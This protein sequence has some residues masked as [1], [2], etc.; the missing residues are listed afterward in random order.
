M[1]PRYCPPSSTTRAFFRA[2]LLL[3]A[4]SFAWSG[5]AA[6]SLTQAKPDL[7]IPAAE[8]KPAAIPSTEFDITAK[9]PTGTAATTDADPSRRVV[10]QLRL[11][12]RTLSAGAELL[13]I[14][15]RLDGIKVT[16]EP[17]PEVPL[18]SV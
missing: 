12:R 15:G 11:E 3:V 8:L 16:G 7:A 13:T 6:Q 1:R 4:I 2:L 5:S 14:F 10:P 18:L 9:V 17:A